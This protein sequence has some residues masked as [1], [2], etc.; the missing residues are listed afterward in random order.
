[1]TFNLKVKY[2]GRHNAVFRFNFEDRDF[3]ISRKSLLTSVVALF[4]PMFYHWRH[5]HQ[6][7]VTI[8][9]S[10]VVLLQ[11]ELLLEHIDEYRWWVQLDIEHP[12]ED[13]RRPYPLGL[14]FV[15]N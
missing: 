1:M 12:P 9:S 14:Y 6:L 8:M 3:R 4:P 7:G 13:W 2:F 10:V 5:H 11:V 15:L